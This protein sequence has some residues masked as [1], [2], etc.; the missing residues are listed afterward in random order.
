MRTSSVSPQTAP[1]PSLS[2]A[3]RWLSTTLAY[4]AAAAVA[5]KPGSKAKPDSSGATHSPEIHLRRG[6]AVHDLFL[7]AASRLRPRT[8]IEMEFSSMRLADYSAPPR[9]GSH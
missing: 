3:A 8:K 5:S 9:L 1:L 6:R 7:S 2:T 4:E